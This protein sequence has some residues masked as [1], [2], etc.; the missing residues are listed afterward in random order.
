MANLETLETV[1]S[2][3]FFSNNIEYWIN[4]FSTFS[5]VTFGPVVTG[6]SLS[7]N[8]VVW[9]E[10]LTEWACKDGVHGSWFKIH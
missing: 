5:V 1:T 6:T 4:K 8:K 10:E 7:E 2:F 3:S 9:S